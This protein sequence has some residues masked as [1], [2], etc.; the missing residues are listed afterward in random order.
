MLKLA[1]LWYTRYFSNQEAIILL[2]F[3]VAGFTVVLTMGVSLAPVFTSIVLAYLLQGV[4]NVLMRKGMPDTAAFFVSYTVFLGMLVVFLFVLVPL[5][6]GQLLRLIKEQVPMMINEANQLLVKL[7]EQYPELVSKE[8]V[9]EIVVMTTSAVTGVVE[10]VLTFSFANIPN[11][12]AVLIFLVLVPLLVFFFLKDKDVMIGWIT[13][14]LPDDRPFITRVTQ[15]MDEQIS[16]YVRGKAIEIFVVGIATY[17]GLVVF[18]V[19][20][21]ALLGLLVGLSVVIPYI[22]AAVVTVPVAMVAYFQFGWGSE[23]F[24]VMM[25]YGIIQGLDGNLLVPLLFSEAVNLHPVAIITAVLLFG[26]LWGVWGVFFAIPLATL[27]KAVMSA[28]PRLEPPSDGAGTD[29][30]ESD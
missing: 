21:S 22:G 14:L 10:T 18:G 19:K 20:Y 5:T 24:W 13:S 30:L 23:F 26:G 11:L 25:V 8:W 7:P 1:Q 28:W 27:V 12:M 17:I 29:W 2:L 9:A 16:N 4:V 3:L 6:W 15:E